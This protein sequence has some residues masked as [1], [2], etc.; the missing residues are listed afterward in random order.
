MLK[1]PSCYRL[2][3]GMFLTGMTNAYAEDHSGHTLP[4]VDNEPAAQLIV[5][6]PIPRLLNRGIV[7]VPL[8]AENMKIVPVY[9]DPALKIMPRIGH[10]HVV[11]DNAPWHWV[12]AS[13]EPIVIQ[14]LAKGEHHLRIE[15]S[16]PNHNVIAF[17]DLDITIP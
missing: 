5:S 2:F 8:H 16:E 17:K 15:L 13:D 4:A 1:A 14:G 12:H 7:V 11:V 6:A 9:G 10:Y 3:V